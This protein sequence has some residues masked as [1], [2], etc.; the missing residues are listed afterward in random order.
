MLTSHSG[1]GLQR[2]LCG[3][4]RGGHSC[5]RAGAALEPGGA[6]GRRGRGGRCRRGGGGRGRGSGG[7]RSR[8]RGR[9]FRSAHELRRCPHIVLN[10]RRPIEIDLIRRVDVIVQVLTS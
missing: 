5:A 2:R 9:L 3:G 8:R 4:A 6:R 1:G 7:R 10:C